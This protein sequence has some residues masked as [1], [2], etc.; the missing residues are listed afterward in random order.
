MV[1]GCSEDFPGL[2]DWLPHWREAGRRELLLATQHHNPAIQTLAGAKFTQGHLPEG[3]E[4]SPWKRQSILIICRFH[5]YKFTNSPRS[6]CNSKISARALSWSLVNTCSMAKTESL[7]AQARL[8]SNKVSGASSA[9][10]RTAPVSFCGL[11]GATLL[12]SWCF[13]LVILLSKK[14][15]SIELKCC[16]VSLSMR[17]L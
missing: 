4:G 15:P 10:Y 9:N 11:L 6:I 2:E 16:L 17:K 8:T 14:A 1:T 7:N 12:T 3:T 5:I 13:V